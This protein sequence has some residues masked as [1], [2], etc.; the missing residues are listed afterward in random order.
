MSM[1]D[2]NGLD[3]SLAIS[4]QNVSKTFY[5]SNVANNSIREKVFNFMKLKKEKRVALDSISFDVKKGEIIGIIGSNGSGKSTLLKILMGAVLP[6]KGGKV[7]KNGK[8]LKLS[9]GLGFDRELSARDNIY[10]NG[11]IIGLSLK[12]IGSLFHK[13]IEFAELEKFVDTKV[14]FFSS[15]MKARLAFSIA[16]YAE[17]EIYL[18]DE[19]FGGVGDLKFREKSDN[20]FKSHFLKDKTIIMVSHNMEHIKNYCDKAICINFGKCIA[21]GEPIEVIKAYRQSVKK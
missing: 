14:K 6:D 19:F 17:A 9:M 21:M 7:V 16:I 1:K 8:M 11:T 20:A 12:K 5:V 15:G 2:Y 3:P 10:V 4:V 13:I 18:F